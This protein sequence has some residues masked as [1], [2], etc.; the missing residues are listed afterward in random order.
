M[1]INSNNNKIVKNTLALYLRMFFMTALTLYTSRVV[2]NTLGISDYGIYNVVGGFVLMLSYLNSVFVDSSQRFITI[3]LGKGNIVELK[4]VFKTANTIHTI[5]SIAL[6]LFAESFGLWFLNHKLVIAPE[7]L[8]A[9]NW[10]FQFSVLSMLITILSIPYKASIVAHEH[11]HIYAYISIIEAIMKLIIVFMLLFV[12]FDKLI[13]YAFLQLIVSIIVPIWFAIYCR[14]KFE[15]CCF[16]FTWNREILKS[17]GAYS[18]WVLVGNLGFT[19]KDQFSN[20]ILN[21][22]LGTSINAA[23]GIA[24]QVNSTVT[25]FVNNFMMAMS[26]QITK[27]YAEGDIDRSRSLVYAGS[28]ISFFLMSIFIVPI[29]IRI[30]Y[31]LQLWLGIVPEYTA[32]FCKIIILSSLYYSMSKTITVAIQAK[33]D[34]KWFQIGISFIML[35]ELPIAYLVLRLNMAPYFALCPAILTNVLAFFFRAFL[36]KNQITSYSLSKL[37]FDIFGR[38]T[39]VLLIS[40]LISYSICVCISD[41]FVGFVLSC[42]ISVAVTICIA[43]FVGLNKNERVLLTQIIHKKIRR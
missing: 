34:I 37:V 42:G 25:S 20:I 11:I 40:L 22:F 35:L 3:S 15:E 2:L 16:A 28:K 36:L 21:L 19:F 6:L 10:V 4:E 24:A 31:V 17:M 30:E 41:T 38:C 26:P 18:G 12:P 23:R 13:M 39:L 7:R 32:I 9:A 8:Y 1:A 43:Y 5:I 33:G 29:Y 27:T 14:R